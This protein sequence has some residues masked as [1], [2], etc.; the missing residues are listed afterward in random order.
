ML[1]ETFEISL[2]SGDYFCPLGYVLILDDA[3][4]GVCTQCKAGTYSVSPFEERVKSESILPWVSSWRQMWVGRWKCDFAL[5][6]WIVDDGKFKLV[7]CP[8]GCQLVNRNTYGV[9]A[10]ES[11]ICTVCAANEC[12]LN[13]DDADMTGNRCPIGVVCNGSWLHG[14]VNGSVWLPDNSTG[15]F[16]LTK[17][18]Q[19]DYFKRVRDSRLGLTVTLIVFSGIPAYRALQ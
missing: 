11:Q 13:S 3:E 6:E 7:R 19:V 16:A 18:P 1:S 2:H 15:L 4:A 10:Q 12:I 14:L 8:R 5:G 9:F 17:C